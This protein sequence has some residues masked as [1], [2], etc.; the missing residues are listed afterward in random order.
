M[1]KEFKEFAMRGS[2]VDLAVG[3]II[4]AAF[5]RIVSSLVDDVVMPPVGMMLGG[6]DFESLFWTLG[7]GE[8]AT[9]AAA[10]EAGAATINYGLF[11]AA[12]LDFVI[13]AFLLFLI[14][15]RINRMRSEP[16]ADT[17]NMK[18]CPQCL[19]PV[20]LA[21]SRCSACTSPLTAPTAT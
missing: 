18:L 7:P 13:V 1:L 6:V 15:R 10:R 4:G 12:I 3:L 16:E 14:V 21:A 9:L 8:F 5:N 17:P 20:P 2:V 11:L 19:T